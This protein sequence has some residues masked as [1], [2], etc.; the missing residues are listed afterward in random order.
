MAQRD[1]K[2]SQMLTIR[3]TAL[4]LSSIYLILL[5]AGVL[6]SRYW[7]FYP[8]EVESVR[9]LQQ[10]EIIS[11]QGFLEQ[12]FHQQQTVT[13]DYAQWDDT[14]QFVKDSNPSY[15]S[16]NLIADTYRT[17][18][19]DGLAI[20]DN[21]GNIKVAQLMKNDQLETADNHLSRWFRAEITNGRVGQMLDFAV[22]YRLDERLYLISVAEISNSSGNQPGNGYL[23]FAREVH[24]DFWQ[25]VRK[26]TRVDFD[27]AFPDGPCR[28]ISEPLVHVKALTERCLR[29]N[30]AENVV[31][32]QFVTA[33]QLIPRMMPAEIYFTFLVLAAI[34]MMLYALFLHVVVEP[35]RIAAR[36]MQDS[37][38]ISPLPDLHTTPGLKIQELENLKDSYNQLIERVREQQYQLTKLSK[39]D[40]LTGIGNRRAFEEMLSQTWRRAIRRKDNIALILIDIDYFKLYNDH[41]GHQQGDIALQ[42]VA[43]ALKDCIKRQDECVFRYGGEEFVVIC[44]AR[45]ANELNHVREKLKGALD[46]LKIR[47][48][49]S[50]IANHLTASSGIAWIIQSG[51]WLN[52]MEQKEWLK[53]ADAA[54]YEA[55]AAGRNC[56]MLQIISEEI[57]FTGTPVLDQSPP[58]L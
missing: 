53:A 25:K 55:K 16:A 19:L 3:K 56:S 11:V 12:K 51:N 49:T 47:H 54:L 20:S 13:Q 21:R 22:F 18:E 24:Y 46:D 44:Y 32:L 57:A 50:K 5:F 10:K 52:N 23:M 14:Y 36:H 48:D 40:K 6:A 38:I 39:T 29:N 35:V 31:K 45:D 43:K 41:Y 33:E 42:Q 2:E 37:N 17:L 1:Q 7:W 9:L 28:N 26:I 4:V 58:T 30:F 34:P 8:K 15:I 27:V